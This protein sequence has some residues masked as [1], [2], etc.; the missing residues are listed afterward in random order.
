MRQVSH[1]LEEVW[2]IIFAER[3]TI[4][5]NIFFPLVF[6]FNRFIQIY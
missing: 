6:N 3:L 1:S 4:A 5:M 2:L